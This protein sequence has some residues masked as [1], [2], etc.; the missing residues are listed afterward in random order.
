[1]RYLLG[2]VVGIFVFTALPEGMRSQ[3]AAWA[4]AI[5]TA[6]AELW[7]GLVG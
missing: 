7:Q 1:M 6:L 4:A 2:A 5:H 3:I